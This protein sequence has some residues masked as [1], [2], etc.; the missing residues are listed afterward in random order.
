MIIAD[1]GLISM[2]IDFLKIGTI[3]IRE[4]G[5]WLRGVVRDPSPTPIV[6]S[7]DGMMESISVSIAELHAWDAHNQNSTKICL[8]FTLLRA[9]FQKESWR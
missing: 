6:Q 5:V 2:K 7:E 9:P 8:L 1:D 4:S 3:P